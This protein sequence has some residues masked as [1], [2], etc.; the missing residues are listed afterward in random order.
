MKHALLAASLVLVAGATVG[1]GGS[2]GGGGAPTDASKEDFCG[3][4]EDFYKEV[5]DL[6][7]D[8][9]DED[10]VKALKDIGEKLEEVGT[11]ED[12]SDD[13]REG[14]ELTVEAINDLPDDATQED[15]E[16][17]EDDFSEDEKKKT[18]AFDDYLA[19]TC[20]EP[21]GDDGT[22]EE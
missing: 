1:C 6:G 12:I 16:K 13:A 19:E 2:D 18:D 4:F 15:I 14:F 10:V 8:A 17:L 20:D 22:G 21:T 7:A 9:S 5:T 3:T 11:P